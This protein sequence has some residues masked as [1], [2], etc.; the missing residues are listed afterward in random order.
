M[1][2]IILFGFILLIRAMLLLCRYYSLFRTHLISSFL[3]YHYYYYPYKFYFND[4]KWSEAIDL[5]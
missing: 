4:A 1:S 2:V 3:F 5:S